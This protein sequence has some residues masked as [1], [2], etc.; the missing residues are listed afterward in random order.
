MD[1][2]SSLYSP[3]IE[4]IA[5]LYPD[6]PV[7]QAQLRSLQVTR[8]E[9]DD[10]RSGGHFWFEIVAPPDDRDVDIVA[11]GEDVD[12]DQIEVI[13]HSVGGRLNWGEWVKWPSST[14][15]S[16]AVLR[17]PLQSVKRGKRV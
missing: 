14:A 8:E 13:L 2:L 11:V 17:W 1:D 3:M 15:K 16:N 9:W 12:G 10:S 6:Y 4:R 7:Q 5:V